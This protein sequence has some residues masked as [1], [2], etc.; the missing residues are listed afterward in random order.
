MAGFY[1]I[2]LDIS[3]EEKTQIMFFFLFRRGFM[4]G[5]LKISNRKK[6]LFELSECL[7]TSKRDFFLFSVIF[8]FLFSSFFFIP[9]GSVSDG[10]KEEEE[11]LG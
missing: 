9:I 3:S 1:Y 10:V 5:I 2:L 7:P 4:F 6:M 11:D 8:F